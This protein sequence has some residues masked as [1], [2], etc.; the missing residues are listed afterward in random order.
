VEESEKEF[1]FN[2]EM[3]LVNTG[4]ADALTKIK[5]KDSMK[6]K[7]SVDKY[8]GIENEKTSNEVED[9]TTYTSDPFASTDDNSDP[10]KDEMKQVTTNV[11]ET[12]MEVKNKATTSRVSGDRRIDDNDVYNKF[13]SS[14]WN[15]K[16]KDKIQLRSK[17][18]FNPLNRDE[19][20]RLFGRYLINVDEEPK[21][22][23]QTCVVLFATCL[24]LN[25]D[26]LQEKK[27][28]LKFTSDDDSFKR[29]IDKRSIIQKRAGKRISEFVVQVED[30]FT[31]KKELSESRTMIEYQEDFSQDIQH[32]SK[33][34]LEGDSSDLYHL[35]VMDCGL[36]LD[37]NDVIARQDFANTQ[38]HMIYH[39]ARSIANILRFLN[40]ECLIIHGDVKCRNFVA[41]E[42]GGKY[43]AI[44]FDNSSN[45]ENGEEVGKKETSSG[46]PPPEQAAIVLAHRTVKADTD[47]KTETRLKKIISRYEA[48][49]EVE[50]D[51]DMRSSYE[52]QIQLTKNEIQKRI[53]VIPEKVIAHKSYDMWCFGVL[54]YKL[55]TGFDLFKVNNQE[56]VNDTV[57]M[58]I[59]SWTEEHLKQM[60][61]FI[62]DETWKKIFEPLLKK[63][64]HPDPNQRPSNWDDIISPLGAAVNSESTSQKIEVGPKLGPKQCL[65]NGVLINLPDK[66][67][68]LVAECTLELLF[69]A[70]RNGVGEGTKAK[71]MLVI[72]GSPDDFTN[73]GYVDDQ[74][75]YSYLF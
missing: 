64:L 2:D 55:C 11:A 3:K 20:R 17:I 23:S 66:V 4:A 50:E 16:N 34:Q 44:D 1:S 22:K 39:I 6:H 30:A 35:L 43:V 61:D 40:E 29:E 31:A 18:L 58:K 37:L 14:V 13:T 25:D 19:N 41:W 10:M 74:C 52:K 26:E 65:A 59:K 53:Q 5:D 9:S 45:I 49:L 47:T 68:R 38:L 57:L 36:G 42:V 70:A 69:F 27:V 73:L 21:H 12:L 51:E 33:I 28:A 46:C 54:L 71:G 60:L 8:E 72:I 67:T 63:L 48:V 56:E 62:T 15:F 75:S 24:V 32:Y 7:E